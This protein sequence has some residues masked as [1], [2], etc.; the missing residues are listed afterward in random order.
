MF[1]PALL[2]FSTLL[3]FWPVLGNGFLQ[4]DDRQ[5]ILEN[6][7]LQSWSLQNIRWFWTTFHM[8]P[9]Q[10]LS[11]MSL[12]VDFRLWGLHPAGYHGMNLLLHAGSALLLYAI[13]LKMTRSPFGSFVGA[14]LFAIHPLRVESVAWVTERRDVLS[15]FFFMAAW[16]TYLRRSFS[17]A[18]VLFVA[19]ALSKGTAVGLIWFLILSNIFVLGRKSWL[20]L[21]PF[22][23]AA[24]LVGAAGW[25]GARQEGL[26]AHSYS[27]I[28]R[29]GLFVYGTTFYVQKTLLPWHLSPLYGLPPHL[30]SLKLEFLSRAIAFAAF[31][32]WVFQRRRRD[33]LPAWAWAASLLILLPVSGIAQNGRQLAADR[34]T[35]L[36]SVP[37]AW[38]VALKFP[39]RRFWRIACVPILLIL[40]SLTWHQCQFWKND[41]ALWE[42]AV[43]VAP[44]NRTAHYNLGT[45]E[46]GSNPQA[47]L[48]EF[49]VVLALDPADGD[50]HYNAAELYHHFGQLSEAS[51]HYRE[52]LRLRP[53]WIQ[54][55]NNL[56]LVLIAMNHSS[57]AMQELNRALAINDHFA[58]ARF[59]RGVLL[60]MQGKRSEGQK[61]LALAVQEQP[62]L[63]QRLASLHQLQ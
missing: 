18:F 5:N 30:S 6:L 14:M 17:A 45:L 44:D 4:W 37:W 56:S 39:D 27:L 29:A 28:E 60:M 1:Y 22:F 19:A 49:L 57:E 54:A 51:L 10:P 40:M 38:V 9:Y 24:L 43:A 2:L 33:P 12:A 23:I 11:W 42:R 61:D 3:S 36:A 41:R 31:T 53:G 55:M 26:F 15:G 58:E 35:Y 63:R 52:C 47:A 46:M 21:G 62:D 16:L 8:G 25:I 32:F 48:R 20:G 50:A 7:H 59:N 13:L 34:Y